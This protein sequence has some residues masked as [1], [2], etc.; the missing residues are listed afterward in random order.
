MTTNQSANESR[1]ALDERLASNVLELPRSA[2]ASG[3]ALGSDDMDLMT[4][5]RTR[6]G[7]CNAFRA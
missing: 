5:G 7:A 4:G 2:M 1:G 6:R 3:A